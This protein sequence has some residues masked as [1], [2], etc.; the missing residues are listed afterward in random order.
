MG[1]YFPDKQYNAK[2]FEYYDL[3]LIFVRTFFFLLCTLM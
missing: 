3:D 2:L 1:H